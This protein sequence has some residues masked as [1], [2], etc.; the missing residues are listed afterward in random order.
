MVAHRRSRRPCDPPLEHR[1][2]GHHVL[3][4]PSGFQTTS[5]PALFEYDLHTPRHTYQWTSQPLAA[6]LETEVRLDAM[7][8]VADGVGT[9]TVRAFTGEDPVGQTVEF[10]I[11]GTGQAPVFSRQLISVLGTELSFEVT[12]TATD[13]SDP[14]PTIHELR[15]SL[16]PSNRITNLV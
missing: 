11:S 13:S 1:L 2:A 10:P 9:V 8:V 4:H 14:A 7:V 3:R 6:T 15:Y 5:D 16:S 12:S